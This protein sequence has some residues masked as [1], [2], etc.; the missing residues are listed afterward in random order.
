MPAK[1]NPHDWDRY[2]SKSGARRSG[3]G[4]TLLQTLIVLVVAGGVGYGLYLFYQTQTESSARAAQTSTAI[5]KTRVVLQAQTQTAIV[6]QPTAVVSL[7]SG[8]VLL[9]SPLRAAAASDAASSGDVYANSNVAFL[10]SADVAG[11]AWWHVRVVDQSNP[12]SAAPGSEGWIPSSALSAPDGPIVGMPDATAVPQA[13]VVVLDNTVF[14]LRRDI[15]T[16]ISV[17]ADRSWSQ[18]AVPGFDLSV[19][20]APGGDAAQ[21]VAAAK[22]LNLPQTSDGMQE[23]LFT[24]TQALAVPST[25]PVVTIIS[26]NNQRVTGTVTWQRMV[27]GQSFEMQ[28]AFMATPA[29]GSSI[30]VVLA[31]VPSGSYA[32]NEAVLTQTTQGALFQ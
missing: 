4:S 17:R 25:V 18:Q 6:Q 15:S 1:I 8:R 20:Y 31:F 28:G 29:P 27:N 24:L 26:Q 22:V 9:Q 19:L 32:Q 3:M 5:A 21:G 11:E 23:A 7:P 30:G 10:E 2:F 14:D 12:A 16:N 13:P